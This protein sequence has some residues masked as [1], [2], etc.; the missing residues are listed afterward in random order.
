MDFGESDSPKRD[1]FDAASGLQAFDIAEWLK[2]VVSIQ[3]PK[4]A[5]LRMHIL[6]YRI[7]IFD[8]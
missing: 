7:S 2:V 5:K 4:Q 8:F 6:D 3:Y 1:F